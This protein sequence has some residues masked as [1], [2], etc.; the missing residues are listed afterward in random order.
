M[1]MMDFIRLHQNIIITG[2]TGTGKSFLGQAIANRAIQDGF[3]VYYVRVSILTRRF[4]IQPEL[5][6]TYTNLL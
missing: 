5:L 1:Q 3:K 2:K 6:R 4:Y